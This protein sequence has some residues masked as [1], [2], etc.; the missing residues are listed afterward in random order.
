MLLEEKAVQDQILE[1]QVE[2][3][4]HSDELRTSE[5]LR[6]ILKFLM[7]KTLSG[8]A[9][10]LKEYTVAIDG[11]G[12]S[13]TYDPQHNSAVRIQVGRLRQ[14]LA[15]YY[16]EEGKNDPV[17]VDLPK[18]RFKLT[19]EVRAVTPA[20]VHPAEFTELPRLPVPPV[21]LA[22]EALPKRGFPVWV[23]GAVAIALA[24]FFL[25]RW[26]VNTR[27]ASAPKWTP[28]LQTLWGPFLDSNRPLLI[29]IEDPL[30]VELRSSPG[31]YFRD[32]SLNHWADVQSSP[33]IARMRDLIKSDS[34]QPSRYYTSFGEAN[35]S[36]LI[37]NLLGARQHAVSFVKTS[38]LSFQQLADNNVIFIGVQNLFFDEKLKALPLATHLAPVLEGVRNINPSPGEPALFADEYSTAPNEEGMVYAVITHLPGPL[39]NSDVESFTS[40]RSA[41]YVGAVQWLTD[42]DSS[43]ELVAKLKDPSTGQM[44]RFYQVLL[45]VQFK[46][47]VPTKTTY[48]LSRVLR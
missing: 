46:D 43:K 28:E 22:P 3:I 44:P 23:V 17:I 14:K 13:S 7:E 20:P 18:G 8:E 12:K 45:R 31:A 21:T 34:I 29:A 38:Q 33:T 41:G 10:Q 15:E 6:Q 2:R 27:T 4:L 11:L 30:F 19:C 16:R 1:A 9:D 40:N 25:G 36:F 39:M 24:A 47:D 26:S 5:V 37:G 48:V 42:P 35:A 32:R